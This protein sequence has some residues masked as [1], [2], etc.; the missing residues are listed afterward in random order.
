MHIPL[1]C[2]HAIIHD[3]VIK[4]K[5][6][7]RY[8]PF[9]RGI[10][11]SPVNSPH[12]GQWRGALIFSL[13]CAWTNGWVSNREAGD[14]RRHR[15]HYDIQCNVISCYNEPWYREVFFLYC[16][17][18][19]VSLLLDSPKATLVT[20]QDMQSKHKLSGIVIWDTPANN[21]APNSAEPRLVIAFLTC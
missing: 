1:P 9:V 12:K 8:W 19:C 13:I 14:L 15:A 2:C 17:T 4:W 16:T 7:L 10:Y 20:K 6:F 5:H 11:L 18:I 3:D 21:T